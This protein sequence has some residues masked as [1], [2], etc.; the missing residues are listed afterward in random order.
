[1]KYPEDVYFDRRKLNIEY[2]FN[3]EMVIKTN[4][5]WDIIRLN[6]QYI[7]VGD[8]IKDQDWGKKYLV[9]FSEIPQFGENTH[10]ELLSDT[11]KALYGGIIP[12][13]VYRRL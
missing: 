12:G 5:E 13:A 6:N 1:M 9:D 7:K 3:A 11:I 2:I 10:P 4:P 8:I